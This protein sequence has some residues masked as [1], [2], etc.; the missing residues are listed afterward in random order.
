MTDE[1]KQVA[2][3]YQDE[4]GEWKTKIVTLRQ[5]LTEE[6]KTIFLEELEKHGRITDAARVAGTWPPQIRKC[7]DTDP[8][9][10]EACT[11]A[12]QTYTDRLI[13]HHQDLVFNGTKRITYDRNGNISGEET[14]YPV[15]LIELELKKHDEGYRDK[16]E[17]DVKVSGG[18]LV[19]PSDV[20]SIEDWEEKFLEGKTIDGEA[21]EVSPED[22]SK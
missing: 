14:I 7:R 9:F 17:M 5:G 2:M 3:Q 4:I 6:R 13:E 16:R 20:A 8:D 18:V 11:V 19:A 12:I 10:D 15:R 1:P 22:D 21:Q